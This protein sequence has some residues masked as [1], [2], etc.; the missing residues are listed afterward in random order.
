MFRFSVYLEDTA[1]KVVEV[2]KEEREEGQVVISECP[3]FI[4]LKR[5]I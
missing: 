2:T 4:N 3:T 1:D 5:Y